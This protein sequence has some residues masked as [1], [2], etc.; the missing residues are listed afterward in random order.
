MRNAPTNARSAWQAE[1]SLKVTPKVIPPE[2][3]RSWLQ[4]DIQ[5]RAAPHPAKPQLTF[6]RRITFTLARRRRP[7]DSGWM[8]R[9]DG[10]GVIYR[11]L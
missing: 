2:A 9:S 7:V 11:M 4:A 6:R 3:Q 5:P 1:M 10:Q 8:A